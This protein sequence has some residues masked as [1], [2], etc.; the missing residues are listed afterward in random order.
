MYQYLS[1]QDVPKFT[2][3]GIF[4]FKMYHLATPFGSQTKAE[5]GSRL[6][7]YLQFWATSDQGDQVSL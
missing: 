6:C 4:V 7:T 2:Q 1:F 5:G 3:I